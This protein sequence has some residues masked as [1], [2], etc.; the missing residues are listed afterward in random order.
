MHTTQHFDKRMSQRGIP[1]DLVDLTLMLGTTVE[2]K[3]VLGTKEVKLRL[4][5][6]QRERALLM[7]VLDKGG[8]VVVADGDALITTYRC[9]KR[10][11]H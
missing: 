4:E 8:V 3:V 6:I 10:R 11:G 5:E 1:R 2:D 7:K 9:E